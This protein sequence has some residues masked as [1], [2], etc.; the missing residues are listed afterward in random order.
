MATNMTTRM[1]FNGWFSRRLTKMIQNPLGPSVVIKVDIILNF[2][3]VKKMPTLNAVLDCW[4]QRS[5]G[6]KSGI[7]D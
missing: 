7:L 6:D 3:K 1:S 4:I 2:S 5:R